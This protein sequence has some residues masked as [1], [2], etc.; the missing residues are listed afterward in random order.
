MSSRAI[1]LAKCRSISPLRTDLKWSDGTPVTAYDVF[2]TYLAIRS[3]GRAYAGALNQ[4]VSGAVPLNEHD[5][6]FIYRQSNCNPLDPVNIPIMPAHAYDPQ[7]TATA[8]AFFNA[9]DPPAE[10]FARWLDTDYAPIVSPANTTVTVGDYQLDS[11]VPPD[12][13]RLLRGSQAINFVDEPD[14]ATAD[15]AFLTGDLSVIVNPLY[16]DRADIRAAPDVQLFQSISAGWYA[17][18]L[19]LADSDHPNSRV[20]RKGKPLD[21]GANPLFSDLRVRQAMQMALDVNGLIAGAVQGDGVAIPVNQSPAS[22]AYNGDLQPATYDRAGAIALLE[23]AGWSDWNG[24]GVRECVKCS[25]APQDTP[26]SFT[27]LYSGDDSVQPLLASVIAQQLGEVGIDVQPSGMDSG[28]LQ[29]ITRSQQFDAYIYRVR[30]SIPFEPSPSFAPFASVNDVLGSGADVTS[31]AN[32]QVDDLLAQADSAPNCSY[33]ERAPLY[34]QVQTILQQDQPY[35][36]LFAPVDLAAAR[37]GVQGF[38]PYP[39]APFWSIRDWR[40]VQ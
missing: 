26:L 39:N 6:V 14:Q 29:Q 7:F 3:Q 12:Y 9:N 32:P 25:T 18:G 11:I 15:R 4:A 8:S 2:Y 17:V 19:N 38:N 5:I 21:Q 22:W 1:F 31:Y 40:V 23:A 37:G 27:L 34:R 16:E 20:D 35:L 10:Q 33:D 13:V 24:D 30:L 36:W 28:A